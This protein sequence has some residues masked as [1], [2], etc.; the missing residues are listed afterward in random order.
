M[1]NQNR[2]IGSLGPNLK[3]VT[4]TKTPTD[5]WVTIYRYT[6]APDNI[7]PI[8]DQYDLIDDG[9]TLD[10]GKT[11]AK[12]TLDVSYP[13]RP[14]YPEQPIVTYELLG[15]DNTKSILEHPRSI[16]Q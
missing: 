16:A 15:N 4:Q 12:H 7:A 11:G 14:G 1:G 5:G 6:G 8:V 2:I 9:A 10:V 13:Y 3:G